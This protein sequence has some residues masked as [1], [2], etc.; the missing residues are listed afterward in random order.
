MSVPDRIG[1]V[2]TTSSGIARLPRLRAFLGADRIEL[3][4]FAR[5]DAMVG[6]G[7]KTNTAR[8]RRVAA[9]LERPFLALEDGFLRSMGLG[10]HGHAPWSL[11]VDDLGIYYDA[12]RTSRL[13]HLLQFGTFGGAERRRARRAIDLIVETNLS[14]Y[15]HAPDFD[16][17]P[18]TSRRVLV[19]DQSDGDLSL[20][21]GR[22]RPFDAMLRDTLAE[23]PDAE[24]LLKTHPDA[25]AGRARS[26]FDPAR[27]DPRVRVLG[28]PASPQHLIAQVD[29]VVTRTSQF[30]FEALM[31]GRSV[32]LHG[33]PFYGGWGLTDDRVS[34]PR[35]TTHRSV[36]EIFAAAYLR[37]ARYVDPETEERCELETVIERLALQR[38][39][40]ER[41]RGTTVAVGFSRWKQSFVPAFV[42]GIGSTVRFG[43]ASEP[44]DRVL[45]WGTRSVD[46]SPRGTSGSPVVWRMEDG[47][48]RSV[49]LGSD[50]HAPSSLVVDRAGMYYDPRTPSELEEL[51][52]HGSFSEDELR[53]ARVLR[54]RIAASGLSKYNPTTAQRVRGRADRDVVLVV[55]QVEDDASIRLGCLDVRTNEALLT[56][57][58]AAR[59]D[60]HLLY[61]PHP[62][63]V[64]GNRVGAVGAAAQIADEV[65]VDASLAEC[66]HHAAEVHTMTSLV[67][68]EALLRGLHVVVY[69]Q[70]FYA[71]WGLTEDRHPHPRRTRRVGLDALVAATLI[72]YPRYVSQTTGQLVP[73]EVIVDQLL[74]ARTET[75]TSIGSTR[76]G[77]AARKAAN[78]ATV[79]L[80]AAKRSPS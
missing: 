30:G 6:W 78:L 54:A 33:A 58:R 5:V 48:L 61:K 18:A 65:V 14:K 38:R 37:Y 35:R 62:D 31:A 46:V 15:N 63:V 80:R 24:I 36:E 64:S 13:E 42:S 67:G 52:Q 26:S 2:G 34:I 71:G 60:A 43:A 4:A 32:T 7:R 1:V 57:A 69:G 17:G 55:G 53:R 70:P 75:P 16:L 77:R 28:A 41:N 47:F 10:K 74:R 19:V 56:E 29:H 50:L 25:L 11:V 39:L 59:P 51:L 73:P 76:L 68:F 72:R 27:L 12:T 9:R 44:A 79:L 66:L 45:V 3:R 40:Q 49:G 23:H 20:T 21:L 8:A 22:A